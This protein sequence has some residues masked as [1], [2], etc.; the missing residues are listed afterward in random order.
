VVGSYTGAFDFVVSTGGQEIET[1]S[2]PC[3]I[4]INVQTGNLFHGTATLGGACEG[5]A[6]PLGAGRIEADGAIEF[7]ILIHFLQE[8]TKTSGPL[9]SGTCS[10]GT[11][12]ASST[13]VYDCSAIGEP[14]Y[15]VDISLN[16]TRS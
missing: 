13:E 5:G 2:C 14:E 4:R 7:S 10:N 11:I 8:C 6:L 1:L 15:T 3:S 12:S 9:L 16:A